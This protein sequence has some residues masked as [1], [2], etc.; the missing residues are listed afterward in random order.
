MTKM[1]LIQ[2]TWAELKKLRKVQWLKQN[3]VCPI[4]QQEIEYNKAVFDHKHKKKNEEAGI[5]GKGLLR[6]V[7]HNQANVFEGKVARL[8]IRYGLHKFISLVDLLRNTADYIEHPPMRP[9]YIHPNERPKPKKLGKRDYNK[10]CKYYF[11][12]YPKR[13][14][15][16]EYPK[17]GKLT[18]EFKAALEKL[19]QFLFLEEKLGGNK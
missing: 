7:L 19:N 11:E 15:L 14:K 13:R 8:Y 4:L 10:I 2:L 5:Y 18:K 16:P 1:K 3:K 9:E 17:S 12:M 6:G